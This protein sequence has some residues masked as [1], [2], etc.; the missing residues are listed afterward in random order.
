MSAETKANLYN[1]L[2]AHILDSAGGQIVTDWALVAATTTFEAIGSG[3][4]SYFV[5]GNENQPVHVTVGLLRYGGEHTT[6]DVA[7]DGDDET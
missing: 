2:Q 3:V 1:A 4:T 5:E 6:F 7:G